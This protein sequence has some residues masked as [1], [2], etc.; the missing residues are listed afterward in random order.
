VNNLSNGKI[1][2]QK[3]NLAWLAELATS[4]A[5]IDREEIDYVRYSAGLLLLLPALE[6]RRTFLYT[7]T[8]ADLHVS[9]VL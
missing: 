9:C 1:V 8:A 7:Q 2:T 4:K 3:V 6:R 5:R